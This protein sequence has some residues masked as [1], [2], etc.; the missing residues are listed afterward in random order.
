MSIE[1]LLVHLLLYCTGAYTLN[2]PSFSCFLM[3]PVFSWCVFFLQ[4]RCAVIAAAN[5]IGG[6]YDPSYSFAE[7]VEL[8]DPILQRFD[9]LCVLQDVVDPVVDER[10][11]SFVVNS[12]MRS[13]PDY[14]PEEHENDDDED[15]DGGD[16]EG[17]K[18]NSSGMDQEL[19]GASEE[20]KGGGGGDSVD[21]GNKGGRSGGGAGAGGMGTTLGTGASSHLQ[22]DAFGGRDDGPEPLDQAT[23]RKYIAYARTHVKPI[24]HD[25]DSEK[26]KLLAGLVA[27]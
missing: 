5:P 11:A 15:G 2:L 16:V 20:S 4:A 8:T 10:L 12:H 7:N 21:G 18:E 26:V 6:R 19:G 22:L 27:E 1:P 13:H 25:I 23:L 3:A 9:V 24:L 17:R 14:I